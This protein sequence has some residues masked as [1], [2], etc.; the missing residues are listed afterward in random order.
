MTA[1]G[2]VRPCLALRVEAHVVAVLARV[3]V[4]TVSLKT[5][6]AFLAH[7]P[8]QRRG[9]ARAPV[10][11]C[12]AAAH[13]AAAHAAH[14][15]CLFES[16]VAFTLLARRGHAVELHVG[17]RRSPDLE[18]HAWVSLDGEPCDAGAAEGYT[19]LWHVATAPGR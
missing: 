12:L 19:E 5:A 18:A 7:L 15:T 1:A 17:A 9:T 3:A 4:R 16:L 2:T 10:A 13:E 11:S 14:P 6:G 8:H